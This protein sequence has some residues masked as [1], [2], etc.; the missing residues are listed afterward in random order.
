MSMQELIAQLEEK[1]KDITDASIQFFPPP[2]VP[3][4]GN[5]SGFELRMLDRGRTRRFA[6]NGQS[7]PGFYCGPE[8]TPRNRRCLYQFRPQFSAVPA[9]RGSGKSGPERRIHRQRHEYAANPDGQFLRVELYPVRADVQSNGAGGSELP[10]QT[11]R[12]AEHARQERPG[13]NG[14]LFQFRYGWSGCTVPSSLP[15]T[16]CTPRP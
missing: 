5:S 12:C 10:D 8:K 6:E 9:P 7:G 14:A 3:G 11:G 13:R 15:A 16:T 2:T 4:F 1:T